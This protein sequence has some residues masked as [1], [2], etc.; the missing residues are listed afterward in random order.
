M[1]MPRVTVRALVKTLKG[2]Y[3]WEYMRIYRGVLTGLFR[4][5]K[6]FKQQLIWILRVI[7]LLTKSPLPSK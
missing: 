4:G 7:K 6:E 3:I 2:G 1:R 5:Y